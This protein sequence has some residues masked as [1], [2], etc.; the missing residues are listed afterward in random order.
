MPAASVG[1]WFLYQ[2]SRKLPVGYWSHSAQPALH[3]DNLGGTFT[4]MLQFLNAGSLWL[5]WILSLLLLVLF[6]GSCRRVLPAL[7]LIGGLLAVLLFVFLHQAAVPR[8]LIE[9]ILP[10]VS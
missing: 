1:A 4:A 10:R 7:F 2:A 8:L 9:W 6:P 5:P 3:P